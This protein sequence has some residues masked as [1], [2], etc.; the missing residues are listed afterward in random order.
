MSTALTIT[1]RSNPNELSVRLASKLVAIILALTLVL[2]LL[3]CGIDK[4][5]AGTLAPRMN[6]SVQ[7]KDIRLGDVFE[8]LKAHA[9]FVLA[10]APEPG[11]ELVWNRPTLLRIAT[12][13]NLPWR[14]EADTEIRIRRA[15]TLVDAGT[16]KAVVRDHLVT[17]GEQDT[18]NVTFTGDEPQV[19]ID[20]DVTPQ[21]TL[22]DFQMQ[23]AGGTFTALLQID[24]GTAAPQTVTLRGVAERMLRLPTVKRSMRNGDIIAERDITWTLQKAASTRRDVVRDASALIGATPRR[25]LAA[26]E[27]VGDQ[28][29]E[30]PRLVSRG[31]IVTMV[32]RH[33]GMYLT[34]KGRAL[35][36]GAMGQLIKVSN[37][38][39][40]RLLEARVS[41]T[42]QVTVN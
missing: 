22:R 30:M 6:V 37:T 21:I 24:G 19:V 8:G 32:Y 38:G 10:P 33:G 1:K 40:S 31:D 42:K 29:L 17:V 28:D 35:E 11:Q 16:L 3:L 5:F 36:D 34:A 7:G 26:G 41:D 23:Q 20:G 9:D 25:S 12:A 15:A 4:A 18:F 13:F 39:S 27:P 2:G 14:P